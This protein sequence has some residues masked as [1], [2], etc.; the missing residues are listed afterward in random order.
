VRRAVRAAFLARDFEQARTAVAAGM[1]AGAPVLILTPEE[2][3]PALGIL[4]SQELAAH[5]R[6][7]FPEV[8]LLVAF[9]C[10]DRAALAHE[11][12]RAGA[13]AVCFTGPAEQT[14]GLAE[15]AAALGRTFY[16]V[17]P[18]ALDLA[19]VPLKR[20]LTAAKAWLGNP[21]GQA[22]V[23]PLGEQPGTPPGH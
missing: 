12:L 4:W 21:M 14:R 18:P 5:L 9:D 13:E 10:G 23:D 17:R 20:R 3:A 1:E 8:D 7:Q 6:R 22:N 2:S 16:A 11:A 15:V 19:A